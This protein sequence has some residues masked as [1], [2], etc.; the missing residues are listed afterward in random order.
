MVRLVR[1]STRFERFAKA[2]AAALFGQLRGSWRRRSALILALLLGFYAGN[3]VTAYVLWLMPGGRPAMVLATVLSL[4]VI[5]R[6]RGR[7]VRETPPLAWL[8]LDNLRIGLVYAVVLDAF[9]LGT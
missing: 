7:W 1:Q 6:L 4:E 3:N 5:V 2:L 9:K 8:L